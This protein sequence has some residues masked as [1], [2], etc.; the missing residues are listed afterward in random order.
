[1]SDEFIIEFIEEPVK[2]NFTDLPKII[3]KEIQRVL[4]V[5]YIYSA[6][7]L[8][9]AVSYAKDSLKLEAV[10]IDDYFDLC[11]FISENKN[12]MVPGYRLEINQ[13]DLDNYVCSLVPYDDVEQ[14]FGEFDPK[15][16]FSTKIGELWKKILAR[17][18]KQGELEVFDDRPD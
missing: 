6:I 8:Y 5:G 14:T 18:R 10:D 17:S 15:K 9:Q 3:G 11:D 16:H 4:S 1:M 7:V 13:Q 12:K 2:E